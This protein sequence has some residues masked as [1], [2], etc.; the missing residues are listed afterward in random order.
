MY[1]EPYIIEPDFS[2]YIIDNKA[3]FISEWLIQDSN[4]FKG[5]NKMVYTEPY[6]PD[7]V[8]ESEDT[9]ENDRTDSPDEV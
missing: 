1:N 6:D 5:K 4:S 3:K 9:N 8:E 2:D 7:A